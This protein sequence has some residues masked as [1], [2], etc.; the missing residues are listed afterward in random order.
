MNY[1]SLEADLAPAPPIT[2]DVDVTQSWLGLL[3]AYRVAS[4]TTSNGKR[5]SVDVQGGARYNSLKQT[6]AI[7]AGPGLGT[8]LGGTET[9]WEPVVGMRGFWEIN[10][11]WTGA[12]LAEF[13]GFGAGGN[14]LS[15]NATAGFDYKTGDR[16]SLK[17][18]LRYTSIDF[19]TTRSD[20]VFA[21]D[22]DSFGPFI[23]Y[24]YTFN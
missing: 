20:G 14:D 19:S 3:A 15:V 21:Y 17:F 12:A 7:L 18:G 5:Y 11:R 4:G 6:V 23:G 9:W 10:D 24:S 16:G 8:T 13:G 2:V 1:L 22:V